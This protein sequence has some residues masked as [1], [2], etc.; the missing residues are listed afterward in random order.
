MTL[1]MS[2]DVLVAIL[3]A[4]TIFYAATLNRKLGRLRHSRAD[5]EKLLAEFGSAAERAEASIAALK[6][7]AGDRQADLL[8]KIKRAQ[9]LQEELAFILDRGD[10][11]A[12][13]LDDLI[14]AGR[15]KAKGDVGQTPATAA[16]GAAGARGLRGLR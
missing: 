5:F 6:K 3:L 15:E 13:Q 7:N 16:P 11:L 14:R 9:A 2:I 1:A 12:N 8:D 10:G 4:V